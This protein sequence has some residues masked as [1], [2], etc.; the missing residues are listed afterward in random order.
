M[1]RKRIIAVLLLS[2]FIITTTAY[3]ADFSDVGS[4]WATEAIEWASKQGIVEGYTDGT[5][6]PT[7]NVKEAEFAAILARYVENTDKELIKKREPGKHWSQAIYNEL[8]QWA[9]PLKGY[10]SNYFKD[11]PINRGD[12]ARVIAAKNGFNLD[13]RQAIY[14]MYE[15]DLSSGMIP[16]QMSF[17]SYGVDKPL[18]R[19]QITQFMKSL[20][21]KGVTTFMGKPSQKG[22]AGPTEVLGIEEIL[23]ENIEI[24]D[25]M[26]DNLAKKKGIT[27]P[28]LSEWEKLAVSGITKDEQMTPEVVKKIQDLGPMEVK[29]LG[30]KEPCGGW[31]N[32]D[33][34]VF[35]KYEAAIK[36]YF[37]ITNIV[38]AKTVVVNKDLYWET[39]PNRPTLNSKMFAVIVNGREYWYVEV[40]F[41]GR[42]HEVFDAGRDLENIFEE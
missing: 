11:L 18:Q 10:D 6:K 31:V 13:E 5:F 29:Q 28:K 7:Q 8:Y 4:Y 26:F 25:E 41:T 19:D 35:K 9:L 20:S 30:S 2:I 34:A 38:D 40:G 36:E 42:G 15:N 3:G 24:T 37:A 14:Y 27:N 32:I 17:E 23:K 1:I 39:E 16:N 33:D 22:N 12:V 21:E